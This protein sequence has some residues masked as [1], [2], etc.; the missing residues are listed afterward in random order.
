MVQ[1]CISG[2]GGGRVGYPHKQIVGGA[3]AQQAQLLQGIIAY[4]GAAVI[5]QPALV[6]YC[7]GFAMPLLCS[8]GS[9]FNFSI[10]IRFYRVKIQKIAVLMAATDIFLQSLK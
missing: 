4:R 10:E 5:Y 2:V 8:R 7:W 6:R 3:L 9:T 1:G